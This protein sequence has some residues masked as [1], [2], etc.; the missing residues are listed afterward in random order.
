MPKK[1]R[2]FRK[3]LKKTTLVIL[4]LIFIFNIS[5][6]LFIITR[7]DIQSTSSE[8][9]LTVLTYNVQ[10]GLRQEGFNLIETN[11][12]DFLALQEAN[13]I[14]INNPAI[15]NFAD[16]AAFLG[17]NLLFPSAYPLASV[18]LVLMT[19]WSISNSSFIEYQVNEGWHPRGLLMYKVTNG[20][21]Q[22]IMA[23]THLSFPTY[24]SAR[25]Q[26]VDELLKLI[27]DSLPVMLLGDFN[28]PASIVDISYWKL[29]DRFNDGWIASGENIYSG[30]TWKHDFKIFRV[31]FIWLS[32]DWSVV[33][34]SAELLGSID[35]DH[36][37]LKMQILLI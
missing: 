3:K 10:G 17:Y 24:Y 1:V 7:V 2:N 25:A 27:P 11:K 5:Q 19:T 20:E 9:G 29:S 8:E 37:G 30:R 35:S 32:D 14:S 18:G 34:D 6:S 12:P 23:T 33:E 36:Y 4:L 21:Q 16:M 28:T 31:D 13:S 26:Q 15:S 22:L